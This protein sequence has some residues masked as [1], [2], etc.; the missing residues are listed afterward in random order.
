MVALKFGYK[1]DFI[2]MNKAPEMLTVMKEVDAILIP[3]GAD[4]DPKY[5]LESVSDDLREY[6]QNNLM[7]VNFSKE[8]RERDPFEYSLVKKYSSMEEFKHLPLLGICRGM[9]M[10]SVAEGIPLYLDIKTELGIPN[11]YNKFD[12][13]IIDFQNDSLMSSL[14]GSDSFKA[15]KLHHQGIRVPYFMEHQSQFQKVR[16]SASSHKQKI[17]EALEYTHRPALGV[18]FHPEKSFSGTANPILGWFLTRACEYKN[19]FK[20]KHK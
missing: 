1:I 16:L 5:Y 6:T 10:M 14:F 4:I 18:Q 13:I 12:S 3:G 7:L 8:G 2:E 20:R 15:F 17:I 11:R 19:Q 9:Q